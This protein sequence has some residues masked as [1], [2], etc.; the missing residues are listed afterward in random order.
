MKTYSFRTT[1]Y[2][3]AHFRLCFDVSKSNLNHRFPVF[4]QRIMRVYVGAMN[5]Q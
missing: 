1:D 4:K 5:K 3:T 2:F